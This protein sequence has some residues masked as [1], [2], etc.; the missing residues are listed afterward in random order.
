VSFAVWLS[1]PGLGEEA[2][3][4]AFLIAAALLATSATAQTLD[5][6][7][8]EGAY[9]R[10]FPNELVT[11][12]T[13]TAEDILEV[14]ALTPTT[15]YLRTRLNFANGHQCS[16]WGVAR[17]EG[18]TLVYRRPVAAGTPTCVLRV[19]FL[20]GQVQF[21]DQGD[22]CR[23]TDCGARGSYSGSALPIASRRRITYQ[24]RLRASTEFREAQAAFQYSPAR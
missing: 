10:S 20:N 6:A 21:F 7:E 22:Q 14:V 18:R 13:Y 17:L 19:R 24:D 1:W 8:V 3:L 11:G 4:R 12:E 16:M 9:R 15:A 23:E 2:T 5:L